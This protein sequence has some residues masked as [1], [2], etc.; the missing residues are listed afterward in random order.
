MF[1]LYTAVI[2]V[3]VLLLITTTADIMINRLITKETKMK[4]VI[5]CLL[6]VSAGMS[7]A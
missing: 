3:T 5:T 2:L 7:F 1:D 4:S 6:I